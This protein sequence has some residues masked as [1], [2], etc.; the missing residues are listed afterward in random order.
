MVRGHAKEVAQA[1]NL[2]KKEAA[3]KGGTQ[4]GEGAVK[5]KGAVVCPVCKAQMPGYKMLETHYA[6]KHP[7]ETV[8]TEATLYG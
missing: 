4:R 1:K 8:P 7:K 2:A 5:M 6:S 3:A